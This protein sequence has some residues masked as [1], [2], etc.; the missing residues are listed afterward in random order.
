MK[1]GGV[2]WY[3][4]FDLLGVH[5]ESDECTN[6]EALSLSGRIRE[7]L[8]DA[9]NVSIDVE[10]YEEDEVEVPEDPLEAGKMYAESAKQ[11][12]AASTYLLD[13]AREN[14]VMFMVGMY[15]VAP[16]NIDAGIAMMGVTGPDY[17][18]VRGDVVAE[19][20]RRGAITDS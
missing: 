15:L 20:R 11:H 8:P 12:T 10:E 6:V 14:P 2:G 13:V 9:T 16:F 1:D 18:R 3:V 7:K 19:L 5:F 17:D 4:Q